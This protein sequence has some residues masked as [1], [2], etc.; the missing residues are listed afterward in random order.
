M[1]RRRDN[2][3]PRLRL[4]AVGVKRREWV[5]SKFDA[6]KGAGTE[7][8]PAPPHGLDCTC[9]GGSIGRAPEREGG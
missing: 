8:R 6:L 2:L 5:G 1:S 9:G 3:R 4:G 7:G